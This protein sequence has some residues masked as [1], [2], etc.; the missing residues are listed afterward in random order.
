M[1]VILV[2]LE[3]IGLQIAFTVILVMLH[4]HCPILLPPLINDMIEEHLKK[5][6]MDK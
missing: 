3:V 2:I 5:K 1:T 4:K 6:G